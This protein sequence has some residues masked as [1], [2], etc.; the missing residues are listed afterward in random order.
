MT[1]NEAKVQIHP[2][3][4][5][6]REEETQKEKVHTSEAKVQE[7]DWRLERPESTVEVNGE[8]EKGARSR[9]RRRPGNF[10]TCEDKP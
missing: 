1:D 2:R 7:A 4:R 9:E 6:T 5:H 8:S 10:V 3:A